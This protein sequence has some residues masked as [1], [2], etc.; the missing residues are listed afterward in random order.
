MSGTIGSH[1]LTVLFLFKE[2]HMGSRVAVIVP[3]EAENY[4]AFIPVKD[5]E[6]ADVHF[7]LEGQVLV[8][9][10]NSKKM[11]EGKE[12]FTNLCLIVESDGC[13]L[14][15]ADENGGVQT[16]DLDEAK[17][18]KEILKMLKKFKKW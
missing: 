16:K 14:Q 11:L 15:Y 13:R 12:D 18:A 8:I 10:S 6:Q 1:K 7:G 17:V 3:K 4:L 5:K 9:G 2:Y